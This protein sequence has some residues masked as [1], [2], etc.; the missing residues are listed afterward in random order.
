MAYFR[1]IGEQLQL[2]KP[3]SSKPWATVWRAVDPARGT[4]AGGSA[5]VA[6]KLMPMAGGPESAPGF[7]R[8]MAVLQA[9]SHPGL[10][11]LADFGFT[12]DAKAF[13]V[14]DWMDGRSLDALAGGSPTQIL[15]AL[16]QAIATV[17]ALERAGL[18]HHNLSPDNLF[19]AT[20]PAG[21]Q[22]VLTGL[23]TPLLRP[24]EARVAGGGGAASFAAPEIGTAA[25]TA[26][27]TAA[28]VYSLALVAC[29]LLGARVQ[30]AEQAAPAVSLPLGVR[31]ELED[32]QALVAAL[33][34]A[35]ARDPHARP[36]CAEMREA[37]HLA[38]PDAPGARPAA[39]QETRLVLTPMPDDTL[40]VAARASADT[41]GSA[42]AAAALQ[43][44]P[45]APH[46][47]GDDTN[48]VFFEE[49]VQQALQA[50]TAPIAA[51]P[52][53]PTTA[54]TTATPA[55]KPTAPIPPAA[56]A[57]TAVP[58]AAVDELPPLPE[59]PPLETD[60]FT[61]HDPDAASPLTVEP[62]PRPAPAVAPDLAPPSVPHIAPPSAPPSAP[63]ALGSAPIP[64]TTQPTPAPAR[65]IETPPTAL[66]P[67]A[68]PAHR[69]RGLVAAATA[70]ALLL[71]LAAA[72]AL[73]LAHGSGG[74]A[75][76]SAAGATPAP[77]TARPASPPP[78]A[79]A[80]ASTPLPLPAALAD[81]AAA[82]ADGRD[83]DA[84]TALAG[85]GDEKRGPAAMPV[86]PAEACAAYLSLGAAL[87]AAGRERVA[88]G[89]GDLRRALRAGDLAQLRAAVRGLTAAERAA[90]RDSPGLSRDLAQ[91][92]RALDLAG[93]LEQAEKGG[94]RL[95]TIALAADLAAAL[96]R[97]ADAPAAR[98]R[99]AAAIEADAETFFQGG[100]VDAA[101]ARIEALRRAWPERPGLAERAARYGAEQRSDQGLQGVLAQA[102]AAESRK[103]PDEGLAI[104]R[105]A[106]PNDRYEAR[107]RDARGRL[108]RQLASLD[109]APPQIRLESP[110]AEYDKGA[111]AHLAF[112]V[113]DDFAVKSVAVRARAEGTAAYV[114]LPVAHGA[115][116]Y[117]AEVPPALHQNRTIE[118]YVVATDTSGHR[119]ELGTAQSPQRLRRKKWY[120]KLLNKKPGEG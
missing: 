49:A 28:D 92:R 38:L 37:F 71:A 11:A 79:A 54:P 73:W 113:T 78:P 107:F 111:A 76:G 91:A 16:S 4:P 48:P 75:A 83:A 30:G 96:P 52:A 51:P 81:A 84:R 44:E 108:E 46:D 101:L 106:K 89:S 1:N 116:A 61:F 22:V 34:R 60:L 14:F 119:G 3:V 7:V 74:P 25:E 85:L 42:A 112:Q 39:A 43:A 23:G 64:P 67:A 99:A 57:A 6:V 31:F 69:R 95:Q 5:R 80:M 56:A 13:L 70:G 17:A 19:L 53:Q 36:S 59:L 2:E 21:V 90:L 18:A 63:V 97:D 32:D 100:S 110:A 66:L 62:A 24:A 72:G 29:V 12:P 20:R 115:A 102:A 15:P 77:P 55:T 93:R 50:V 88:G 103:R 82:F 47:P 117:T 10:P 35:L 8:G 118:F 86:V 105:E 58:E 94:D 114:D 87:D 27:G 120:E 26:A 109:K 68:V 9:L 41:I 40:L 104:L 98:E 45:A 33:A 65:A